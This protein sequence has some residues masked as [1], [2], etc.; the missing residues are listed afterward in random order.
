MAQHAEPIG[1]R[2]LAKRIAEQ[3]ERAALLGETGLPEANNPVTFA[4]AVDLLIRRGVLAETGP[5][6]RD[7]MLG[8]GPEWA[9]L[10]R[11]RERLATALRPR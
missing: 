3:F 2:A 6:R 11:L 1:R 9:E 7:P 8:H 4:N 5:D 10:E